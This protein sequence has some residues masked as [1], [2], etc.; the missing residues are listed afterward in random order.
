MPYVL[1]CL[2]F[3]VRFIIKWIDTMRLV[4]FVMMIRRVGSFTEVT[5]CTAELCFR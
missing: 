4:L 2:V 5:Q 1:N 3:T